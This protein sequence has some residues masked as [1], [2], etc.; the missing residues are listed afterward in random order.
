MLNPRANLLNA[1]CIWHQCLYM[2]DNLIKITAQKRPL[3]VSL[4][5]TTTVVY[6]I[7]RNCDQLLTQTVTIKNI[8][9]LL[10]EQ[11]L[12]EEVNINT[13]IHENNLDIIVD[14][15]SVLKLLEKFSTYRLSPVTQT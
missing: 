3:P 4:S 10:Q 8:S 9:P 7:R 1:R 2:T 6:C 15:L 11:A 5:S 13:T 14:L 12:T